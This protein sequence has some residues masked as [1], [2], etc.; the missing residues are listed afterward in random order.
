MET[1]E[2]LDL[3][4]CARFDGNGRELGTSWYI[5]L[6][7]PPAPQL[8]PEQQAAVGYVRDVRWWKKKELVPVFQIRS[9]S[10]AP[11]PDAKPYAYLLRFMD[12]DC[13]ALLGSGNYEG[14]NS[15][16]SHLD[17]STGQNR[18][19]PRFA[20]ELGKLPSDL[21]DPIRAERTSACYV[22]QYFQKD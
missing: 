1:L 18:V 17:Y 5:D 21:R 6:P 14:L 15:E 4:E 22:E 20:V 2:H 9:Y 12:K 8:T 13:L 11:V 10:G 16:L 19:H 7:D 3:Y